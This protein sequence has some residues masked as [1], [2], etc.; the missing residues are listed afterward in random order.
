MKGYAFRFWLANVLFICALS[1]I[2]VVLYGGIYPLLP[3][4]PSTVF[5]VLAIIVSLLS[6]LFA[7]NEAVLL[8]RSWKA[9]ANNSQE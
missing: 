6:I 9:S 1:L 2:A 5:Q 8:Y 4:V 7:L 3:Q